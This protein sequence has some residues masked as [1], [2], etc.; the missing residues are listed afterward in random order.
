M[1]RLDKETGHDLRGFERNL[2][3]SGCGED[4]GRLRDFAEELFP[5]TIRHRAVVPIS[6]FGQRDFKTE[7]VIGAKTG[8]DCQQPLKAADHESAEKQDHD[9]NRDL[10]RNQRGLISTVCSNAAA[11]SRTK[12]LGQS[13]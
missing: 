3:G 2:V 6:R 4:S 5:E 13:R 10:C 1:A 8:I 9:G 7:Q 11:I 12:C